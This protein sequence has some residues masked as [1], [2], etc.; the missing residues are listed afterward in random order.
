MRTHDKIQLCKYEM[1]D[2]KIDDSNHNGVLGT[3]VRF[4]PFIDLEENK[5]IKDVIISDVDFTYN[6]YL[7]ITKHY[8]EY[9]QKKADLFY[10]TRF[11]YFLQDRFKVIDK[12]YDKQVIR[13]PVMAGTV[14][15]RIKIPNTIFDT[16]F[17]CLINNDFTGCER[18]NAF[19]NFEYDEFHQAGKIK[20]KKSIK[21]GIDELLTLDILKY[22][23]DNKYKLLIFRTKDIDKVVY[24]FYIDHQNHKLSD[25]RFRKIVKFILDN[26]YDKKLSILEN[27]NLL[28][29]I[30]YRSKNINMDYV[31]Y[32][33]RIKRMFIILSKK[34]QLEKYNIN[35]DDVLCVNEHELEENYK[36]N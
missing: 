30:I 17:K 36:F 19:A 22:I 27:Y 29:T 14:I 18:Y 26:K 25:N 3:V 10:R 7:D 6:N 2:F 8:K 9:K 4:C 35:D 5:N 11:C 12:Y 20:D 23:L 33:M 16:F 13:Y 28:D 21:Y 31:T 15:M 24:K 32:L 34:K 1:K